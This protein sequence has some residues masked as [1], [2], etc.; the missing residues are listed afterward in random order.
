MPAFLAAILENM[1]VSAAAEPARA[2]LSTLYARIS[3]PRPLGEL[4]GSIRPAPQ[5]PEPRVTL[6]APVGWGPPVPL[7]AHTAAGFLARLAR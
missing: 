6:T 7:P 1:L 5:I 3:A 2:R 4:R